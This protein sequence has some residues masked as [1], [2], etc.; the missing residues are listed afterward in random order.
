MQ[1]VMTELPTSEDR[2][3]AAPP[4]S[5]GREVGLPRPINPLQVSKKYTYVCIYTFVCTHACMYV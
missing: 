2:V 5:L 4:H 3:G 1:T